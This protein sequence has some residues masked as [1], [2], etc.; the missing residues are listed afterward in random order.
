[1]STELS[2]KVN[3]GEDRDE[4]VLM[5]SGGAAPEALSR[6]TFVRLLKE[7]GVAVSAHIFEKCVLLQLNLHIS[8]AAQCL[9]AQRPEGQG[10]QSTPVS[11]S[12]NRVSQAEHPPSTFTFARLS[13]RVSP[14]LMIATGI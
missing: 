8:G 11:S 5:F 14:R 12:D 13:P 2:A 3:P 10:R 1:M 6:G 9:L 7:K 4:W